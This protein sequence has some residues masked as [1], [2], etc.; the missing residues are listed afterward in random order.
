LGFVEAPGLVVSSLESRGDASADARAL[1]ALGWAAHTVAASVGGLKL[2]LLLGSNLAKLLKDVETLLVKNVILD[3]QS[4]QL[5]S[6]VLRHEVVKRQVQPLR[7]ANSVVGNAS[8]R[9]SHGHTLQRRAEHDR[10]AQLS[11]VSSLQGSEVEVE[12]AVESHGVSLA[13]GDVGQDTSGGDCTFNAGTL[14]ARAS[15]SAEVFES[16]IL[17]KDVVAVVGWT[18]GSKVLGGSEVVKI[19]GRGEWNQR[20]PALCRRFAEE[21]LDVVAVVT[22]TGVRGA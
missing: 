18:P 4:E 7:G 1:S 16:S 20:S 8:G 17:I 15:A 14:L 6:I 11:G 12:R 9:K 13:R 2:R 21:C 19:E 22:Q 5:L 3:A 10:R